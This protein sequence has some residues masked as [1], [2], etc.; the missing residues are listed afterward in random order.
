MSLTIPT[1]VLQGASNVAIPHYIIQPEPSDDRNFTSKLGTPVYSNLEFLEVSGTS[2]DNSQGVGVQGSSQE[3]L[4]RDGQDLKVFLRVDTVLFT[5][6]GTKN[7]IKT[8]IQGRKGTIKEYIS[9][10]DYQINV[11]GAIVSEFPNVYPEQDVRLLIELLELPKP[12]PIASKFLDMFAIFNVVI[13]PEFTISEKLGSR[14]EVPFEFNCISDSPDD[15]E[16]SIS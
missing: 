14:N 5:V 4:A 8:A 7:V 3:N 9:Q 10:G 13:D 11:K 12:I 2:L 1:V 15:F 16:L 6:V